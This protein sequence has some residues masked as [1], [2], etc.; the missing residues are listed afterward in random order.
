METGTLLALTTTCFDATSGRWSEAAPI[1]RGAN[2]IGVA[3]ME[4]AVYALGGFVEQNRIAVPD[5]YAYVVS[6]DRW[7]STHPLSRGSRGAISVVAHTGSFMQS[8]G[9]ILGLSNGTKRMILRGTPGRLW[10]LFQGLGIM[11]PRSLSTI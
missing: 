2:H 8:G 5:C 1:P 11:P 4:G 6:D 7:H 3:A 10:R 9:E